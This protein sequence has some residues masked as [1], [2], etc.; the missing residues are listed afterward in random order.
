M[1]STPLGVPVVP[2]L[3]GRQHRCDDG[4]CGGVN[5]AA[6]ARS[7][8]SAM[9][10]DGALLVGEREGEAITRMLDMAAAAADAERVRR[11]LS[12]GRNSR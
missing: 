1:R 2:E 3:N 8:S 9:A 11:K 5:G 12:A 7:E 10:S 4:I 6:A